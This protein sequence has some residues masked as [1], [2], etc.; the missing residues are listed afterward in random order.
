MNVT[1]S[2][3]SN[4]YCDRTLLNYWHRDKEKPIGSLHLCRESKVQ[5]SSNTAN[6]LRMESNN[7][8]RTV[9]EVPTFRNRWL[10]KSGIA[11][12]IISLIQFLSQRDDDFLKRNN[13]GPCTRYRGYR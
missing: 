9:I 7:D 8:N 5:C 6:M 3:L 4:L 11:C 1:V 12:C 2:R 10:G 13:F